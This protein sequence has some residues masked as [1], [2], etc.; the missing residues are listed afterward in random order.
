MRLG[1]YISNCR[2]RSCTILSTIRLCFRHSHTKW[3][4]FCICEASHR[5]PYSLFFFSSSWMHMFYWHKCVYRMDTHANAS[6]AIFALQGLQIGG[7]PV[8]LSW[9][10]DR[11]NANSN[12]AQNGGGGGGTF[13]PYASYNYAASGYAPAGAQNWM[14]P[15]YGGGNGSANWNQHQQYYNWQNCWTLLISFIIMKKKTCQRM[16]VYILLCLCSF[17]V[18]PELV[19]LSIYCLQWSAGRESYSREQYLYDENTKCFSVVCW[20]LEK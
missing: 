18:F 1:A 2:A 3:S 10:K 6:T 14:Q 7:R 12:N 9:G 13:D 20:I 16:H 19:L 17:L 8:R 4:W 15:A 11:N 5:S